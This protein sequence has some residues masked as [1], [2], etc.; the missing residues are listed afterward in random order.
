MAQAVSLFTSVLV[1]F[2]APKVL[3]MQSFGY[4]QLFLF[5]VTY[6]NI[7][8][9]GVIDGIYLRIGGREYNR[10]DYALYS[11]E[12]KVFA[13]GQMVFAIGFALFSVMSSPEGDRLFVLLACSVCI[14]II[15]SNNYFGYILLAVYRT[16]EYSISVILQNA[17][18]FIAILFVCVFRVDEYKIL[19]VSYV[20]GHVL[21]GIFLMFR[22]REIAFCPALEI[23]KAVLEILKDARIGIKLMVSTYVSVLMLGVTRF[24]VDGRWGIE[25][26]SVFSLAL[27]L[28][29]FALQFISQAGMVLFPALRRVDEDKLK[30]M[31]EWARDGL[32]IGFPIVLLLYIPI[33]VLLSVWLPQYEDS[34]YFMGLLLPLCLYDGK[35]QMLYVT[36]M[37]V[38][39]QEKALMIINLF[40][41]MASIAWSLVGA[42][43]LNDLS[44]ISLGLVVI[45][46][47][48]SMLADGYLVRL[49]GGGVG[50]VAISECA[51]SAAYLM[52]VVFLPDVI[53]LFAS[54][55]LYGIFLLCNLGRAKELITY[56]NHVKRMVKSS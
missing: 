37:K 18:W 13:F 41:L 4:W 14:L 26:F 3:G 28:T 20:F 8:R 21:A 27:S 5:Y 1:S 53:C 46:A 42:Y 16:K 25:A 38:L 35:M 34:F 9:L 19:I 43:L 11:S 56:F 39:R 31:Y 44:S 17:T 54:I 12:W 33:K 22:S 49:L 7:S 47:A 10:L 45:I 2:F 40:S 32:S 51:L 55:A 6:V 30:D 29:N 36:Y 15:N 24:V 48:R 50:R 52:C 23:R